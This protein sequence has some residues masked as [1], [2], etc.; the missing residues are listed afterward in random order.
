[1]CYIFTIGSAAETAQTVEQKRNEESTMGTGDSIGG[2]TRLCG[3]I[4]NPVEHT[5]S[6]L[7]HNTLAQSCGRDMVY[8]PFLVE[9][10]RLGDAVKGAYALNVL[11][12]NIT[13]PYKTDVVPFLES[14]EPMAEAIGSVNT[15]VRSDGGY[16][17]YNTDMSGLYRAMQEDGVELAGQKVAVLGA[18]G[19]GRAVAYLCAAKGAEQVVILNRSVDKAER[20]AAEVCAKT[21]RNVVSAAGL[22]EAG[23]LCG[24]EWVAVQATSVGLYP[25]YEKAAVED[26]AFYEK[27]KAGYDLIYR[28]AETRFMKL[29]KRTGAPAY[30]GLKMLLYQGVEAFELWN[31]ISVSPERA[32]EVYEKLKRGLEAGK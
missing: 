27:V 16:R 10:G 8:V 21:G 7:I 2:R 26:M 3:L 18:G 32:Q 6:P 30:N 23:R 5:L 14:I 11:G 25:E 28:P 31:G 29:V 15:L 24:K 4:G 20:I 9:G 19:V 1:M 17:G 13:V 12:L 22:L